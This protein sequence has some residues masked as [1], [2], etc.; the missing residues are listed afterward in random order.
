M[1][2]EIFQFGWGKHKLFL[3]HVKSRDFVT[4]SFPLV[5]S[6]ALGILV[7]TPPHVSIHQKLE[8]TPLQISV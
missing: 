7:L 4:Y 8:G 3:T 2:D 5:L 1:C 6:L